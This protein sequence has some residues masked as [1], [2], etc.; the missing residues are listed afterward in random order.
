[1]WIVGEETYTYNISKCQAF[2]W[3][4]Y[5]PLIKLYSRHNLPSNFCA[6]TSLMKRNIYNN[7]F[8]LM[9]SLKLVPYI[10]IMRLIAETFVNKNKEIYLLITH[11][12]GYL[13]KNF[14]YLWQN[15]HKLLWNKFLLCHPNW[16]KNND[17]HL[18][19]R[20]SSIPLL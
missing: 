9:L 7:I 18:W 3:S 19:A 5:V 12:M 14:Q 15:F 6:S 4:I 17:L 13:M 11:Y 16:T 8:Y 1:M 2:S 20:R 10:P